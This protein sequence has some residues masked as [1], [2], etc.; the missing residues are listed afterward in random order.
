MQPAAL[1]E[2]LARGAP[3]STWTAPGLDQ[4]RTAREMRRCLDAQTFGLAVLAAMAAALLLGK[5]PGLGLG[6]EA[7][8]DL[9]PVLDD[10]I[11]ALAHRERR[12]EQSKVIEF[13]AAW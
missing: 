9:A 6:T 1:T 8:R 3:S 7:L 5:A 4:A 2:R 11:T 13:G 10:D 12:F